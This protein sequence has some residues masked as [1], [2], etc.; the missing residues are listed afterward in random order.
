MKSA[1]ARVL[2]LLDRTAMG[3]GEIGMMIA[4]GAV[5]L[6]LLFFN[7]RYVLIGTLAHLGTLILGLVALIAPAIGLPLAIVDPLFALGRWLRGW[8]VAP[9]PCDPG[10]RG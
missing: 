7:V 6:F 5:C 10:G 3:V 9:P 2:R 1:V 4:A 8:A